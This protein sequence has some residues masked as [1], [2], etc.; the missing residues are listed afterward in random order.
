MKNTIITCC[1]FVVAIC[2][3]FAFGLAIDA[4]RNECVYLI[5]LAEL[6]VIVALFLAFVRGVKE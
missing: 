4:Y 2:L 6:C 5:G 3:C 1:L